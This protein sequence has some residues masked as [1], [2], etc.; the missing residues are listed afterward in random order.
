MK[1][2]Q[3]QA[4]QQNPKPPLPPNYSL[5]PNQKIT[6]VLLVSKVAKDAAG[7]TGKKKATSSGV[8]KKE[9]TPC[10]EVNHADSSSSIKK[11]ARPLGRVKKVPTPGTHHSPRICAALATSVSSK[12]S[13][14]P[15]GSN[16]TEK[17]SQ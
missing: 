7:L 16:V 4:Q 17:N 3:Q 6:P 10:M 9:K 2:A 1:Q 5:K 8:K 12:E 14:G 13:S 15:T 11:K